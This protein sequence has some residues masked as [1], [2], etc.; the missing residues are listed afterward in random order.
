MEEALNL[1]IMRKKIQIFQ[2]RRAPISFGFGIFLYYGY[3]RAALSSR[4]RSSST[5]EGEPTRPLANL[6]AKTLYDPD[7]YHFLRKEKPQWRGEN[8][9]PDEKIQELID[10]FWLDEE[11]K[12]DALLA[13][14]NPLE[15]RGDAA[16]DANKLFTREGRKTKAADA[17][18]VS[19]RAL[20]RDGLVQHRF[21]FDLTNVVRR[22]IIPG[23]QQ[24]TDAAS[25]ETNFT[26]LANRIRGDRDLRRLQRRYFQT[27]VARF[28]FT[29]DLPTW[30][31]RWDWGQECPVGTADVGPPPPLSARERQLIE[32]F[33]RDGFVRV[34][35]FVK[36]LDQQ[37][38]GDDNHINSLAKATKHVR[39]NDRAW[40]L[41]LLA[42]RHS[43]LRKLVHGY[44][45]SSDVSFTGGVGYFKL[46]GDLRKHQYDNALWHH[47]G[48][49]TRLK[50][51][52]Y[53][54]D[55]PADPRKGFPTRIMRN[56]HHTHW[57]S[58]T[59]YFHGPVRAANKL[60]DA[61]VRT[62]FFNE[63]YD[64]QGDQEERSQPDEAE[65]TGRESTSQESEEEHN[66][67]Q[68]G[69]TTELYTGGRYQDP[70]FSRIEYMD[71]KAFGGFIFD[72][73]ALHGVNL[74]ES[75]VKERLPREVYVM[76]FAAMRHVDHL[77]RSW[78]GMHE[79]G[80]VHHPLC[81]PRFNPAR[82]NWRYCERKVEIHS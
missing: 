69:T 32:D 17:L 14:Y 71:G 42:D 3:G 43:L 11:K 49:G 38:Q 81:N 82:I 19:L 66:F 1:K 48:C 15:E 30:F 5:P 10:A 6:Q 28:V 12:E 72:T 53:L 7:M 41:P 9:L 47:D 61:A 70:D 55:V 62:A 29:V 21:G 57:L 78:S 26:A 8:F 67:F 2:R 79:P 74:E 58:P 50:V 18:Q 20:A 45:R 76:E 24:F 80:Y 40:L 34:P 16:A 52:L 54:T 63:E 36:P 60:Q 77:P 25:S 65:I 22:R 4:S 64:Q 33:R 51:Y 56:T 31:R 73:N 68:N 46:K 59:D 39:P 37:E 35:S 13:W 75:D 23:H 44:L 27:A